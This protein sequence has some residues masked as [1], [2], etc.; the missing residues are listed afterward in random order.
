M[1]MSFVLLIYIGLFFLNLKVLEVL[2]EKSLNNDKIKQNI[3]HV[4]NQNEMSIY[5]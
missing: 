3:D 2:R 5:I 1:T 4:D